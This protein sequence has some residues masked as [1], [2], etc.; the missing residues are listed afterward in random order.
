MKKQKWFLVVGACLVGC[1]FAGCPKSSTPVKKE[2]DK[3]TTAPAG[4]ND[5]N[6][7]VTR[8]TKKRDFVPIRKRLAAP[9][10]DVK[11]VKFKKGQDDMML[12]LHPKGILS[13]KPMPGSD[14][15]WVSTYIP[16]KRKKSWFIK[17]DP[18]EGAELGTYTSISVIM[19]VYNAP[20]G[21]AT[22][23]R[24]SVRFLLRRNGQ[25]KELFRTMLLARGQR[26]KYY[27]VDNREIATRTKL[28]KGD[29]LVF[30]V[31]HRTGST[32]AVG[33][34]GVKQAELGPRFMIST[35]NIGNFY[36]YTK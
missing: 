19:A 16:I 15:K 13:P 6:T 8:P 17:V 24:F 1:V 22:T 12:Y 32:G 3:K 14:G 11:T 35:R 23:S 7:K 31:V 9:P 33:V 25:E 2:T 29:I 21:Y 28:Q 4:M 10:A 30:Q 18:E 26:Y 27:G 5:T 20:G 34:G 36:Q